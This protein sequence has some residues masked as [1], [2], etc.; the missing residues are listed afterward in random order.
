MCRPRTLHRRP[1]EKKW[2]DVLG[3][4]VGLPWKLSKAHDGDAE[5]FLDET[6]PEPSSSSAVSPLPPIITEETIT[7]IRNFYVYSGDV[8]PAAGGLGFT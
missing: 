5:V 1:E 7:K 8:D 6:P 4:V 3:F 2:E